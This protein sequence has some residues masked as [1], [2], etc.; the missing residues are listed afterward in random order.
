MVSIVSWA[1]S[2]EEQL[3][4]VRQRNEER[5]WGF[6]ESDFDSL[7]PPPDWPLNWPLNNRHLAAVILDVSLDTVEKT[8]Q[9]AW[10]FAIQAKRDS[11]LDRNIVSGRYEVL[12][13]RGW[14]HCRGM[15]W[16]TMG[17]SNNRLGKEVVSPFAVLWA[18][19]YFPKWVLPRRKDLPGGTQGQVAYSSVRIPGYAAR[20]PRTLREYDLFLDWWEGEGALK[21]LG[22]YCF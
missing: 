10:A 8:F 3:K 2:P 19:G 12:L 13:T 9:E 17:L 16:I 18:V 5:G 20:V 21:T 14:E 6:Q 15:R 7:G 4:I 22:I 11:F 1:I